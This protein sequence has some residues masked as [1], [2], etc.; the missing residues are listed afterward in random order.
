M[1]YVQYLPVSEPIPPAVS[2]KTVH[3]LKGFTTSLLEG[4]CIVPDSKKIEDGD[5]NTGIMV[6]V[7]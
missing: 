4:P 2:M 3:I 7:V 6:T 1:Q 5:K